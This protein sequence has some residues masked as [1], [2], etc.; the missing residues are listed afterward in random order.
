[1]FAAIARLQK[2]DV[3]PKIVDTQKPSEVVADGM[4]ELNRGM[5]S[6][7]GIPPLY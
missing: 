6:A 2:V 1:M 5:A 7:K 3:L 4:I